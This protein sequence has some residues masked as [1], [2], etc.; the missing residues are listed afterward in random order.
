[1]HTYVQQRTD[2]VKWNGYAAVVPRPVARRITSR[3]IAREAG[4]SQPTVSRALRGDPRVAPATAALVQA[5]ARRLGYVPDAAAQSLITRRTGTAAIVVADITNPFY[6][7][8]VE[9]LHDDLGRAGYRTVLLNERT[10]A[11]GVDTLMRAGVVDGAIVAT[12]TLDDR[13]RTLLRD[14]RAPIVQLVR[15]VDGVGRDAVVSDN[16]GGAA[17][18]AEHLASLGHTRI[19]QISGPPDTS[20]ARDRDEGFAAALKRLGLAAAHRRA[21]EYAH[22]TGYQ[23]CLELLDQDAPPTAIFCGNDVVALGALDAARRRD[24]AVPQQLS[25]VGFDDI[26]LA[27]W[28]SFRLTTVRQ[29]LAQMAHAAVQALIRR[30]EGDEAEPRRTVFPT[31]L[32]QRATTGPPGRAI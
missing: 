14:E 32:I 27:G 11:R 4:V 26:S 3:D 30:I 28:E 16:P 7:E 9:A 18:V 23:W 24:V 31:E 10:D 21:G 1:M 22:R 25:I 29:P 2:D 17:L 15:E 12:A 8:L 19:G 13:T 20:T 5:T 6:P